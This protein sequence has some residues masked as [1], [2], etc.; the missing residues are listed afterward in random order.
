MTPEEV[1][2]MVQDQ[3]NRY[4]YPVDT[5]AMENR[6]RVFKHYKKYGLKEDRVMIIDGKEFEVAK[7]WNKFISGKGKDK[8]CFT[9]KN[10]N[11]NYGLFWVRVEE[12]FKDVFT[13]DIDMKPTEAVIGDHKWYGIEIR[14]AGGKDNIDIVLTGLTRQKRFNDSY[15][16]NSKENRDKM[17][18]WVIDIYNRH[19]K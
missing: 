9:C 1:R 8:L 10:H 15:M 18:N 19:N 6:K 5:K 16:F 13:Q 11:E 3:R 7:M 12:L 2:L 14:F 17:Y 4:Y